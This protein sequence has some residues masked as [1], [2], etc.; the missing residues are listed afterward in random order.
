MHC[1]KQGVS[2]CSTRVAFGDCL[3]ALPP[4]QGQRGLVQTRG[5]PLVPSCPLSPSVGCTNTLSC[6]PQTASGAL[7]KQKKYK[8][9]PCF[10]KSEQ[11]C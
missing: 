3:E 1:R 5:L 7:K 2:K 8:P 11:G 4:R 6:K 9:K 10:P